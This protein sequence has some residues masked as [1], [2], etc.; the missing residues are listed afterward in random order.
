MRS[1]SLRNGIAAAIAVLLSACASPPPTTKAPAT[2]Y[3]PEACMQAMKNI[4]QLKLSRTKADD[5]GDSLSKPIRV[6]RSLNKSGDWVDRADGWSVSTL[7]LT[8]AGAS[9][10]SVQLSE[11]SL[12]RGT[13]IWLCSPNARVRHG[14]YREDTGSSLWSPTVP[15]DSAILQIWTPSNARLSLQ[16]RLDSVQGGYR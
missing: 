12:P 6:G 15:G 1:A 7:M 4:E 2:P 9:S 13:Q 5:G 8:S 3:P 11:L 14:P 16:G 10:L